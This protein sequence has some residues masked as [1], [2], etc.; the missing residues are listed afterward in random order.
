MS[1]ETINIPGGGIS[2][3]DVLA[4]GTVR[5]A[6]QWLTHMSP[7]REFDTLEAAKADGG[8]VWV[9]FDAELGEGPQWWPVEG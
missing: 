3:D 2:H 8:H 9:K 4:F 5:T 6:P 1:N 7:V